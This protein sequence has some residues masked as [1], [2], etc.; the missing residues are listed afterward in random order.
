MTSSAFVRSALRLVAIPFARDDHSYALGAVKPR[1]G[2]S[3]LKK[4]YDLK[5]TRF[6][7]D[8]TF[9]AYLSVRGNGRGDFQNQTKFFC[10]DSNNTAVFDRFNDSSLY[11]DLPCSAPY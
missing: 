1:I 4:E 9:S 2:G 11:R 8:F 5:D 10:P 6:N 7:R 3:F